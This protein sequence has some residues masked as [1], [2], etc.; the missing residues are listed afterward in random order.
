MILTFH[1][2]LLLAALTICSCVGVAQQNGMVFF[3]GSWEQ[4]MA[5]A[6]QSGKPVFVDVYT[7]WCGPCKLMAKNIF[8]QNSVGETYN[9]SFINY[10]LDAETSEG[11]VLAKQYNVGAYPTFLYLKNDGEMVHKAIGYYPDEKVFIGEAARALKAVSDPYTVHRM[12]KEFEEGKRD[13]AFLKM[14]IAKL[15]LLEM[16]NAVPLDAYLNTLSPAEKKQLPALVF[17]ADNVNSVA[18]KSFDH[19]MNHSNILFTG[20]STQATKEAD[21]AYKFASLLQQEVEKCLENDSLEQAKKWIA[22]AQ[23]IPGMPIFFQHFFEAKKIAYF[24]KAGKVPEL[25]AAV[26]LFLQEFLPMSVQQ[27]REENQKR[28]DAFM[29]PFLTGQYDS[30]KQEE[31]DK[32]KEFMQKSYV[33]GVADRLYVCASHF[34]NAVKDER[35]LKRALQWSATAAALVPEQ[36]QYKQLREKIAAKLQG[37]TPH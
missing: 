2:A 19:L 7:T 16:N 17:L 5:E 33:E 15:S 11:K 34:Y 29:Q 1:K 23:R 10:K 14:Y 27:I 25:I 37:Q 3:E 35:E 6:K 30:T 18:A 22:T 32:L 13:T 8:P 4:L 24:D 26:D 36:E 28:Y 9:S 21:W 12:T 31:F 20:D